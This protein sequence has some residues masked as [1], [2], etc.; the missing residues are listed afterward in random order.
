MKKTLLKNEKAPKE[1]VMKELYPRVIGS[2]EY[3]AVMIFY[4]TTCHVLV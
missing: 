2:V 4:A 3:V 1:S